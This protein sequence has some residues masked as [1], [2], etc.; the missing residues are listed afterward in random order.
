[1]FFAYFVVTDFDDPPRFA[2]DWDHEAKPGGYLWCAHL[3]ELMRSCGATITEQQ[4]NH[5]DY[6]WRFMASLS[7]FRYEFIAGDGWESENWFT[8]TLIVTPV[9]TGWLGKFYTG[10]QYFHDARSQF[11]KIIRQDSCVRKLQTCTQREWMSDLYP[12]DPE[13]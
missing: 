12:S 5:E 13:G 8:H 6:A 3:V 2:E 10:K 1:M 7:G 11:D 4:G 9:G